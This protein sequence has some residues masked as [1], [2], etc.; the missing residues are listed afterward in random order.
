MANLRVDKITSTE[1]FER[2]GSVYFDGSTTNIRAGWVD[3]YNY[4]HHGTEDWTAEF[5]VYPQLVNS[6]QCIFSTG[7]NSSVH[8]FT[9]RIMEQ[10][11]SGSSNGYYVSAQMSRGAGGNYIYW[12]SDPKKLEAD[13]WYHIAV[14]FRSSDRSLEIYVD[15]ELTNGKGD[16]GYIEGTFATY[17]GSNAYSGLILGMEPYGSSLKLTIY[18]QFQNCTGEISLYRKL[19]SSNERT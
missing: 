9:V 4:L 10:G 7:G 3:D 13:T 19:Q 5:W 12:S 16:T 18:F 8:G 1:T 17:S 6:R 14:V 11:V 15:G 2:T